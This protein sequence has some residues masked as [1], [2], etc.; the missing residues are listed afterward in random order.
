MHMLMHMDWR[1]RLAW[2]LLAWPLMVG[3]A[4]LLSHA[5]DPHEANNP[6]MVAIVGVGEVLAAAVAIV[7]PVWSLFTWAEEGDEPGTAGL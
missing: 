2:G 5:A 6:W 3:L 1:W 4:V 7:F